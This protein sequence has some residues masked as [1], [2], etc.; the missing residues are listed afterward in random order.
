MVAVAVTRTGTGGGVVSGRG[1]GERE[2]GVRR[3]WGGE[4]SYGYVFS[5]SFKTLKI[6]QGGVIITIHLEI[7]WSSFGLLCTGVNTRQRHPI[8]SSTAALC[9]NGRITLLDPPRPPF[10]LDVVSRIGVPEDVTAHK[11]TRP[12]VLLE[13]FIRVIH[14]PQVAEQA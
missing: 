6:L 3:G 13:S 2:G 4:Y 1:C 8:D 14:T 7:L 9:L 5:P 12:P 11:I 10:R